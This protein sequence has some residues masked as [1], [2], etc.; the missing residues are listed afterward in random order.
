LG[1]HGEAKN[2]GSWSMSFLYWGWVR[3]IATE[4]GLVLPQSGSSRDSLTD[5]EA[6]KLATVLRARAERIRKGIAP[7]DAASFVQ[8][9]DKEWFPPSEGKGAG[10]IGADFDSP[11]SIQET[12]NFFETSGGVTLSY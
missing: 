8:E 4:A 2:G 12:A 10:A 3:H 9:I 11:E 7:R 1:V 5:E 6:R